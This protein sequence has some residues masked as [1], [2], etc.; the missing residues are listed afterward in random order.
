VPSFL[1]ID[2][3]LTG[4]GICLIEDDGSVVAL[5]TIKTRDLRGAARLQYIR[6]R[7]KQ[8]VSRAEVS[9]AVE[10]YAYGAVGR[11]F[12]LGEVGGVLRL[13]LHDHGLPYL[14]VAPASLKL[15]ATGRASAEKSDVIAAAR[16]AGP[17]PADDNQADAFFLAQVARAAH[18]GTAG[19][20]AHQV[21]MVQRLLNPPAKKSRR[22]ARRVVKNAV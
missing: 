7:A 16:S 9:A 5:E 13:L 18:L 8:I 11:V 10:A 2:P 20:P 12:E 19:L 3:S 22:R 14:T 17:S 1:G 15:F 21:R 6:D 4:T